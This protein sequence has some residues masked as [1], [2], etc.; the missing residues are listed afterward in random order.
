VDI[1]DVETSTAMRYLYTFANLLGF[2]SAEDLLRHS[3][4]VVVPNI[5]L[6]GYLA[7]LTKGNF[8]LSTYRVAFFDYYAEEH[9]Q[10]FA[11]NDDAFAWLAQSYSEFAVYQPDSW[12]DADRE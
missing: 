5:G 2:T 8:P 11:D 1:N 10:L 9:V 7:D 4:L 12:L 3:L 6:V